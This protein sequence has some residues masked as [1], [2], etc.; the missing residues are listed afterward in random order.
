[1][2][3]LRTSVALRGAFRRHPLAHLNAGGGRLT[4]KGAEGGEDGEGV[5]IVGWCQLEIVPRYQAKER[6]GFARD[7]DLE[8]GGKC[9]SIPARH[10]HGGH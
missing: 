10:I 6:D 4:S 9:P 3:S 5:H 7:S 1:M 2:F 8:E